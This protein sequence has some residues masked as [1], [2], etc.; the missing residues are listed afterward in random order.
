LG[1]LEELLE[2]GSKHHKVP[3]HHIAQDYVTEYLEQAGFQP[4]APL[5]SNFSEEKAYGQ[6]H[7]ALGG[8]PDDPAA[9]N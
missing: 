8:L 7:V 1:E 2:K 4:S 5:F 6:G 9:R 3:V